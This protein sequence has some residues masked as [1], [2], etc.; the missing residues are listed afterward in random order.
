MNVVLILLSRPSG[1]AWL[2]SIASD[3]TP[4]SSCSREENYSKYDKAKR[5]FI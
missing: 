5:G 2:L 3:P 4:T 1:M